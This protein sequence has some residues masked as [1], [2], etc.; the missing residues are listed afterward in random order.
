MKMKQAMLLQSLS[1]NDKVEVG[2]LVEIIKAIVLCM[3]DEYGKA[4][5]QTSSSCPPEKE[6]PKPTF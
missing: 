3:S 4:S 1:L 5:I 2:G 6:E